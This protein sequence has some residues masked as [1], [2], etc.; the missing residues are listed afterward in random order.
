MA[1]NTRLAFWRAYAA[2]HEPAWD[3]AEDERLDPDALG[4]VPRR[5]GEAQRRDLGLRIADPLSEYCGEGL[6]GS[7][8]ALT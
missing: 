4:A 2:G 5:I 7:A 8:A 1:P 3:P 6:P